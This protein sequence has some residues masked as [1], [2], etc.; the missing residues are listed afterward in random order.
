MS[1]TSMNELESRLDAV[2]DEARGRV[3]A[4]QA[5]A[6]ATRQEIADRFQRFLPIAERIVVIAREKLERLKERLEFEVTPSQVQSERHYSRSVTLDV[7]TELAGVVRLGFQADPRLGR[8]PHPARLQP[9][10][11]PRLLPLQPARPTGDAAGVL[12]R[13]GRGEVARRLHRRVRPRLPGAPRHEAV[14]GAGDGLRHVASISFPKYFAAATLEHEG[15][16][17]YFISEETRREFA[18]RHGLTL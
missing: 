9:G 8:A 6:E 7:K 11:Y 2:M 17:Y 4:F 14:P 10:N 5:Q 13:G 3:A 1:T 18:K 16:T 12:R 15:H